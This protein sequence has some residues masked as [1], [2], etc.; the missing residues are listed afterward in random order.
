MVV[1]VTEPVAAVVSF[2]EPKCSRVVCVFGGREVI[3]V[4]T[5]IVTTLGP[6]RVLA[7][8]VTFTV[9]LNLELETLPDH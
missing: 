4:K 9:S 6:A 3:L 2:G 1:F 7:I 8:F 5:E